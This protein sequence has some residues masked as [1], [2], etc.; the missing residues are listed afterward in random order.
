MNDN[1]INFS[2]RGLSFEGIPNAIY[3]EKGA[4][5]QAR[6]PFFD[7]ISAN[8]SEHGIHYPQSILKK[9]FSLA[10]SYAKIYKPDP[11]GQPLA[12]IAI[13]QYYEGEGVSLPEDQIILTPGTSIS[14]M[15]LFQLLANPGDEI[16]C[17][18]PTY[19]LF[20][21]I[22]ALC[23]IK[24]V[25]Y[26]LVPSNRWNIDFDHLKSKIS[27]KTRAIV[28]ISPHNP[29]GA[30]ATKGEIKQLGDIAKAY[31]LPLI[32]DE[33]F[34]PFLFQSSS[35]PRP[36]ETD[37]PLVFTLNGISKMLA[38]PG[39]KIG[40]I[41]VSGESGW[42][43]KSIRILKGI[44]DTYLP[45]NEMAQFALPVLLQEGVRPLRGLPFMKT[46]QSQI[47]RR[48]E[49]AM[50]ILKKSSELSFIPPEG[51]FYIAVQMNDPKANEEKIALEL[52]RK[53]KILV[54][55]GYFYD[56]PSRYLVFSH[57]AQTM[58]I[59]ENLTRAIDFIKTR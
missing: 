53:E 46:Y 36:V 33:V 2:K 11:Q 55:P 40:W 34:S 47:K 57:I 23:N 8:T 29:T 28:L 59:R 51:G 49:T 20:D 56:L 43:R 1:P 7:F 31:R 10:A 42:V 32:S 27:V 58:R 52:L 18:T 26:R 17:P 16:L 35:L 15:Y 3:R 19:P 50:S 22:A 44:S 12:R 13:Q 4:F 25:S 6:T 14:Y 21:S 54:H 30:V 37:A 5:P 48:F 38:L 39:I 45:V 41:G 9:A 24:I